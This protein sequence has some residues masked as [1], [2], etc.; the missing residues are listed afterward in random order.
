[1][2]LGTTRLRTEGSDLVIERGSWEP[3]V[4]AGVGLG[5]FPVFFVLIGIV[6]P[7]PDMV[8]MGGL[9]LLMFGGLF[10]WVLKKALRERGVF[11]V[12][13]VRLAVETKDSENRGTEHLHASRSLWVVV[14]EER[15]H[16][17]TVSGSNADF[18]RV[19]ELAEWIRAEA[20]TARL[21]A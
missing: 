11:R 17:V 2:M 4:A 9:Y 3:V 1:M 14:G 15:W 12:P 21:G 5:V 6:K 13:L 7:D 8:V 20:K 19:P 10:G 16:V 18:D